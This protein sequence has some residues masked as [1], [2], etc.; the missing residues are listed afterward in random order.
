M[1]EQS[2]IEGFATAIFAVARAEGLL[3]DVEEELF[4]FSRLLESNPALAQGLAAPGLPP[5]RRPAMVAALL[6]GKAH[7]QTTQLVSFVVG[8]GKA[9]QLRGIVARLLDLVAAEANKVVAEVRTAVPLTADQQAKLAA[10]LGK[11]TGKTV[12][13]KASVDP[14]VLGGVW[15]KVGDEVVDGTVAMRLDRFREG[16]LHA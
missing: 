15:A 8:S 12:T 10:A 3:A 4:R 11:A 6:S 16:L 1:S 9:R 7:P 2:V 14:D 5:A 13:L